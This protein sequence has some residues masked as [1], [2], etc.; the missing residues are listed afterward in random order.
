MAKDDPPETEVERPPKNWLHYI[1]GMLTLINVCLFI[2]DLEYPDMVPDYIEKKIAWAAS[3]ARSLSQPRSRPKL[4]RPIEAS[5]QTEAKTS[6][7]AEK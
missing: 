6:G 5:D 7:N 4:Q 1:P 2:L 3:T